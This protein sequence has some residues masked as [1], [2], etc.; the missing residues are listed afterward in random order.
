MKAV[1]YLVLAVLAIIVLAAAAVAIAVA[2]IDPNTYKPQIERVVEKA[3]NLDLVLEGDIG[4]SFIPLGLEL[5]KVE[6]NLEGERFVALEQ[7]VAQL[8]FWSLVKM[9]PQ[10]D[11]FVLDG[12]DAHLVVNPQGEGNWTRIIPESTSDIAATA[13]EAADQQPSQVT[14]TESGEQQPLNFNVDSVQISNA[15]VRYDDQATGQSFAL[16]GVTANA[17]AITLGKSFPLQ[18][19][20][21]V[22][23]GQPQMAVDGS[24]RA[25][26]TANEA[27][28]RFDVDGLDGKFALSGEPF[29]AQTVETRLTGALAADLENETASI[30]DLKVTVANLSLTSNL[31]VNGFGD[32]PQLAGN[33]N[34]A[35]FSLQELL[36]ALGQAPIETADE[37]V[38]QAVSFKTNLNGPAGQVTLDN[39]SLALDDTTLTGN[40]RYG[41]SNGAIALK[42]QGDSF[43]L[44]RY[45]PPAGDD[46]EAAPAAESEAPAQAASDPEADLL[47]LETLRGLGLD[48]DLGLGQLV[49]SN[50]TISDL[51]AV[52]TGNN[53]LLKAEQLSANL[54]DGQMKASATLD[55]RSDNPQWQ[56]RQDLTGVKMQPLLTDLAELDML[57]GAANLVVDVRTNGNSMAAIRSNAKGRID[58]NLAEGQFTRM[59]LTRMAC[60]GIALANQDQLGDTGWGTTTPFND[61]HGTLVIDGNTLTNS[62]LVAA[63]A[64]MRLEG[65]GTVDLAQS[66]VDYE[67][68]LRIVGEIH[69]DEACRVTK[70]VENVIIPVECRG[71]L[72]GDTAKLC[73]FDGSRFRDTLKDMAENAARAKAEEEIDRGR[74]RAEERI[75]EELDERLD[76]EDAEKVK[77]AIR[78]LFK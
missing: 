13:A 14:S 45:L 7:L 15:R 47:P 5:N 65:N 67:A 1:R 61:M 6:A 16:E 4:W 33:L 64:G 36:A 20:F 21:R 37:D 2:V 53:G 50:L 26:L 59:N 55:A 27:L 39:L 68:G 25:N 51:K 22:A 73:S 3:T 35:E 56:V 32:A 75:N 9:S 74:R 34:I 54:Y 62:D 10:V 69:R 23:L 71:S 49:A 28:N 40:A 77:D 46:N 58:F 43:N 30:N 70:Y 29:G 60:R 78:G 57:D 44:D 18:L 38:L 63:L 48:I 72:D 52:I 76:S 8:D 19:A 31:S 24:V 42:L 41:L 66:E 17:S 11:T 12:L